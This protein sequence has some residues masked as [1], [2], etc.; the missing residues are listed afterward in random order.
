MKT[1]RQYTEQVSNTTIEKAAE[2]VHKQWMKNQKAD[3]HNSHKSPD[4]KEEYMTHY[5]KL[6]D[7]AKKIDRDCVK[8]VLDVID[9]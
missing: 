9:D 3:G 5:G 8:A 6:S 4:G 2:N 1:F 7:E